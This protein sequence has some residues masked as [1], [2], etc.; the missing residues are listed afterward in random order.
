MGLPVFFGPIHYN[1]GEALKLAQDGLAF[2]VEEPEEF[3]LQLFNLLSDPSRLKQLG[4]KAKLYIESQAGATIK[5][6]QAI[7]KDLENTT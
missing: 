2:P 4:E 6:F 3:K 1:S 7:D 5:S